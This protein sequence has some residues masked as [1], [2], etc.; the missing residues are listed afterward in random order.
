MRGDT[1]SFS[2][3]GSIIITYDTNHVNVG[4]APD[5]ILVHFR[6]VG[7]HATGPYLDTA[8][9]TDGYE[10]AEFRADGIVTYRGNYLLTLDGIR[11][12]VL[13]YSGMSDVGEDAYEHVLLD[14]LLPGAVRLDASARFFTSALNHRWLNKLQCNAR[15]ERDFRGAS[16][17]YE[18]FAYVADAT[19][20]P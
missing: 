5:L 10:D 16:G 13:T 2:S 3:I 20:R 19:E 17:S 4:P 1:S 12:L 6:A 11:P 9:F 8:R 14:D 15:G 18:L 7:A